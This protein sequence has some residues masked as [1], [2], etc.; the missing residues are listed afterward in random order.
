MSSGATR[1]WERVKE[2]F[3]TAADLVGAEREAY[4]TATCSDEPDVLREVRLLLDHHG[5]AE[6]FLAEPVRE[7]ATTLL[8]EEPEASGGILGPYQLV[9][10]IGRGGMGVV[11]LAQRVGDYEQQVAIKVIKRGMDTEEAHQRFLAE[12]QILARLQHPNVARILDG[13]LTDDGRPYFVMEYVDGVPILKHCEDRGLGLDERIDLFRTACAA[14]H[15]AHQNL[16]LHRDLKPSNI[17]IQADGTVKLLDFG[18]AKVLGADA[19]GPAGVTVDASRFMTLAH[20][21]PEQIRNQPLTTA[22]DVYSLGVLLYKMLTGARPYHTAGRS[23]SEAKRVICEE[24]PPIP[25]TVPGLEGGAMGGD[26]VTSGPDR[27][28]GGVDRRRL[29]GD[30]DSIVLKALSKDPGL[31]YTSAEQLAEDLRRYQE[32]LPVSSRAPSSAYRLAK[33]VRRHTLGVATAAVVLTILLAGGTVLAVQS[34]RIAAER[35][36]AHQVTTLSSICS[37]DPTPLLPSATRSPPAPY[38]TGGPSESMRS[39]PGNRRYRP[40]CSTPL[41]RSTRGSDSTRRRCPGCEGRWLSFV[42]RR[43]PLTRTWRARSTIWG[44]CSTHAANSTRPSPFSKRPWR[45]GGPCSA[46]PTPESPKV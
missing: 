19:P 27:A 37:G 34:V 24:D 7:L 12:R 43:A 25:S 46:R 11:Y 32:G 8:T 36:K 38:S 33:F 45:C 29:R 16:V 2:V 28:A 26:K 40:S 41:G 3:S 44:S 18:V 35:D 13:G 20:A 17:L 15:Y 22:S 14:V 30:L 10:E 5:Q 9:G 39:L 42:G 1:R 21:S 31:R 23:V 4:L 6:G